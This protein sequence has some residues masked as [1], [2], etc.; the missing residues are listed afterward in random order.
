MIAQPRFAVYIKDSSSTLHNNNLYDNLFGLYAET[1]NADFRHNW[2]GSPFGPAL[3]ERIQK[4]RFFPLKSR[5]RFIPW[6]PT[7]ITAAGA[8]WTVDEQRFTVDLNTSSYQHIILPGLDTDED[9]VPDWW[10]TKWGYAPDSWDDHQH[11]DPDNDGLN[12]IEECYTDT[13]GSNPFHQDIFLEFDWMSS[14]YASTNTPSQKILDDIQSL[15]A[16]QNIS[17]HIDTGMLNGSEE[18]PY[19][20]NFTYATLVDL[21]WSY[22]LH[23]DMNNPRK[24]IFHYGII[25]DYGT[26]RGFA[27]CGWDSLDSF[28]ISAQYLVDNQPTFARELLIVGGAIHELGHTLGLNVDDHGGIDNMVVV[29]S[30]TIQSFL[31]RNYKSCM[32]YRYTYHILGYSD[33][34]HGFGDFNDW[35]N[36]D[37]SF[38]KKTH[39]I[40]PD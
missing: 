1:S 39:F 33:G 7:K 20:T 3:F 30:F 19:M 13:Y 8:S 25:C 2:W 32:N 40:P 24:G 11:L 34:S 10:E 22:F 28:L 37:F 14:Q 36:I 5:F 17:L 26:D 21:Y 35:E 6:S 16:D 15:F 18:I 4:D 31:F 38:F 12:N 27:F 9:M 29:L 23:N